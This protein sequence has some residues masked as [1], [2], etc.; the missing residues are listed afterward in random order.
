MY[1]ERCLWYLFYSYRGVKVQILFRVHN[2]KKM[3]VFQS[4][5]TNIHS[6]LYMLKPWMPQPACREAQEDILK[7]PFMP[8]LH[9]SLSL[10]HAASYQQPLMCRTLHTGDTLCFELL[11]ILPYYWLSLQ[12]KTRFHSQNNMDNVLTNVS[13]LNRCVL[14]AKPLRGALCK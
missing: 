8:G 2:I 11:N 9:Y 1:N 4:N 12:L 5:P 7:H 6:C 3:V 13:L 14:A 10:Q